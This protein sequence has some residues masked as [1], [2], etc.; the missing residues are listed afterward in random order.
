MQVE[1]IARQRL[2]GWWRKAVLAVLVIGFGLEI[3]ITFQAYRQAP[4]I[5]ERVV[6]PAGE[7]VFTGADVTAGQQVFLRYGLMENGSIWGHGAY[8]GP[9]FSAQYLH[10]LGL[11]ANRSLALSRF[12]RPFEE[13]S[14]EERQAVSATVASRLKENRFDAARNV[15][16]F[17]DDE[18]RSFEDQIRRWTDYFSN[19]AVNGGLTAGYIR[20]PKELRDLTAFFAWTAWVSIANRPGEA[21]SYTNNFPYDPL[22]GNTPTSQMVLWSALS[23]ITLLT[24]IALVL[25][26]FGKFEY[27][28]WKG[29]GEHVH[30]KMLPGVAGPTQRAIIKY[31]VAASLLFLVQVLVGGATAH[32]RAEP[33]DF[34]GFDLAAFLPSNILRTWHLQSA[35]FWIATSFVGGGLL[36]GQALGEKEPK[37][38]AMAIHGLFWALVL[39][40]VGSLLGELAGINRLLGDLWFWFGHQGWEYLDLGRGW[41]IL[42]AIGL[43]GWVVLLLRS[44]MPALLDPERREISTLFMLAA[45]AIPIFYLPAFFFGGATNFTIVDNWRFWII[46]LWVEGFFELF[47]TVMVAVTFFRLGLVTRLTAARVI[48]LDAILFLGSGIVGTGH[49]W[50]FSGQTNLNLSL[51]ALFS[52]M[53]VVPLTLLTLDAWDFVKLTDSECAVCG[54]RVNIPHKWAFY[55]LMAVGFWNFVGAGIFGFLINLPI[56]SYFEVGTILTPNHGHMA[57]MGVFGMEA[58]ALMVL[59]FRQVLTADQWRGPE[60]FI[61]ISFWGLNF[62]LLLMVVGSLFPGGVLQVYDVLTNGYWHARSLDYLGRDLSRLIEWGRLPGDTVFIVAGVAPMAIAAVMTYLRMRQTPAAVPGEA[63]G[64]PVG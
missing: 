39:V 37:G 30:P 44:V 40:V 57:L 9:D 32:Y 24:G 11:A 35:I 49:H 48:Y 20:D 33:G 10:D 14:A 46:H 41:Q 6:G 7:V 13:L 34:Y 42:L 55:F 50:Y 52:A 8:L 28:G 36:L 59:A 62:G 51:S 56:V 43:I 61:R 16:T 63:G 4:P 18:V 15:L 5:P 29:T 21:F 58:L 3:L 2:S 12:G 31:F 64:R 1:G 17:T 45:S 27:L 19:P 26:A 23:L 25:F 22:L 54:Q 60:R 38:Q 53:E 47:V